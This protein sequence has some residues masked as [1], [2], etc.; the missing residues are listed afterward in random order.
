MIEQLSRYQALLEKRINQGLIKREDV[1]ENLTDK[2]VLE[3]LLGVSEE[4]GR[5]PLC[6]EE[7]NVGDLCR[8][9]KV[10]ITQE[11]RDR[12]VQIYGEDWPNKRL[13]EVRKQKIIPAPIVLSTIAGQGGSAG[14]LN[15]Y[16]A[17][18]YTARFL[19]P[20]LVG[21]TIETLCEIIGVLPCKDKNHGFVTVHQEIFNQQSVLTYFRNIIYAVLKKS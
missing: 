16:L 4:Y 21:D 14:W 7:I 10:R 6:F 2:I 9:P 5:I 12:H 11:M 19:K 8:L 18:S 20:I 13:E 17:H 1:P 3:K 15:V